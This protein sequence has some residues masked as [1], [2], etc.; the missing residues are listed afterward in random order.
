MSHLKINQGWF[1]ST[2]T[3]LA[4]GNDIQTKYE[5]IFQG[6]ENDYPA[7]KF[8]MIYYDVISV[9]FLQSDFFVN[10]RSALRCAFVEVVLHDYYSIMLLMYSNSKKVDFS[11]IGHEIYWVKKQQQQLSS[12]RCIKSPINMVHIANILLHMDISIGHKE[13]VGMVDRIMILTLWIY[14]KQKDWRLYGEVDSQWLALLYV[15]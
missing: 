7:F 12:C 1:A 2:A 10:R 11:E 5:K 15:A 3:V 4:I 14:I 13:H 6:S 8:L 9:I